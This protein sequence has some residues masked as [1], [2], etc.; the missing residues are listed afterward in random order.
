MKRILSCVLALALA[1][2]CLFSVSCG[3][4]EAVVSRSFVA[5]YEKTVSMGENETQM[6]GRVLMNL[7]SDGTL[8]LYVGFEGMGANETAH[9]TG[10][11]TLGENE[12]FDETISF[13]YTYAEGKSETVT[14]AVIIDGI[15]ET[16]FYMISSMTSNAVKFYETAPA[17]VD[18]DVYVG[19]M[20][21]VSGMGA[22]VYAYALNMK[23][24]GT[25]DVS[26]MQMATVMH[27]WDMSHGTY[28]VDGDK[29]TFSYD[30]MDGE[31]AV[32]TAGYTSEG[33][34]FTENGLTVGF[35]IAQTTV[36]A[37]AAEFIRVK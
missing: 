20:S 19:Y 21:K 37:S 2:T 12:E 5:G 16:P 3:E 4:K 27:V 35:N 13:T 25:F 6:S 14:D 36:R 30:V 22:T 8:D 24:D 10:T 34:G 9:Y 1:L 17:S 26:I 23:E 15:F 33:T 7:M 32:A 18:G 31:G 11:Y 28:T 29:V